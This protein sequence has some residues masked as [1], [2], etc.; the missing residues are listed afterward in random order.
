METPTPRVGSLTLILS[1]M[2][3]GKTTYL[4]H[5]LGTMRYAVAPLYINTTY[6]TRS[7]DGFSTH[8]SFIDLESPKDR[9]EMVKVTRLSEVS[10]DMIREHPV[11]CIDE[12]QFFDDLPEQVKRWV[13]LFGA[14]V[15]VAGLAGDSSRNNFGHVHELLPLANEVKMLRDTLCARCSETKKRTI[16]LFTHRIEDTTGSQVQIGAKAYMP[17]CRQCYVELNPPKV[18]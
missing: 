13:E 1:M 15:Y 11:V 8:N 14:D 16:A 7:T 3:G 12:G 17:V 6:D 18:R 5:I 9:I 2:F 4:L 10:D